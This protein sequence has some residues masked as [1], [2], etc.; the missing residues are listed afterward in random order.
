MRP[1]TIEDI[2]QATAD[3]YGVEPSFILMDTR[4]K[5]VIKLRHMA[6]YLCR[7]FT[8]YTLEVIGNEIAGRDHATALYA[9]KKIE[10]E[11]GRYNDTTYLVNRII[12]KLKGD[13]FAVDK[14]IVRA[15]DVMWYNGESNYKTA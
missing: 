3:V 5:E 7:R 13:G 9:Y 11:N 4:K 10:F 2:L 1:P 6:Q 14:D 12:E 15:T 8:S